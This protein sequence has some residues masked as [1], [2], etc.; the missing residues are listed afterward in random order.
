[1]QIKKD[2]IRDAILYHARIEFQ[3]HGYQK[4][5]LRSIAN[6][7]NIT[8]SNIY[9]YFKNK[10]HIFTT[11]MQPILASIEIGKT[12]LLKHETEEQHHDVYDHMDMVVEP[13]RFVDKNRDL[14]NLLVFKANGSS[15]GNFLNEQIDWFTESYKVVIEGMAKRHNV[16]R[17]NISEFF[18]HTIASIWV[19]FFVEALMHDIPVDDM[20]ENGKKLMNFIYFGWCGIIDLDCNNS[21]LTKYLQ[22]YQKKKEQ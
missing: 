7:A 21:F 12:E 1:M 11:I 19:N 18:I 8:H 3:E 5:S 10:D 14:F 6:R 13:V 15:L 16:E 2:I 4:A 22:Q 17:L 9:H 20:I